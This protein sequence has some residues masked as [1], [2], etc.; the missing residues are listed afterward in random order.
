MNYCGGVLLLS[1]DALQEKRDAYE[2][3]TATA[4]FNGSHFQYK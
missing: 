3:I 1:L 4:R 2:A